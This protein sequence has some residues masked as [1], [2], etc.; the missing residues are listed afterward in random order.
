MNSE[1]ELFDASIIRLRQMYLEEKVNA[2]PN[3]VLFENNICRIERMS[4]LDESFFMSFPDCFSEITID[5]SGDEFCQEGV[6]PFTIVRASS[7]SMSASFYEVE[8]CSEESVLDSFIRLFSETALDN[9]GMYKA[10]NCQVNWFD[11]RKTSGPILSYTFVFSFFIRDSLIIGQ[12]SC[13]L[14]EYEQCSN[15][16]KRLLGT[17]EI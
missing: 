12:M 1:E 6:V 11:Y 8:S 15:L 10:K 4:F 2:N 13:H 7:G 14:K 9:K 16:M 17:L 3:F 5:T